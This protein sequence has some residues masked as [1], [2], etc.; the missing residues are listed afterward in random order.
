[1]A[2]ENLELLDE[3]Y[4]PDIMT[5][6]DENGTEYKFEVIDAADYNDVR[7]LAAVPY[8]ENPEDV[9]EEDANLILFRVGED[10]EGGE[11]VDTVEDDEELIAVSKVF[12][13]RLRD[14]FDIDADDIIKS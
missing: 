8:A 13:D 10:E 6:Q 7:Y 14:V 1:M 12:E 4:E 5:L 3:D 11:Y 9:V 2:D